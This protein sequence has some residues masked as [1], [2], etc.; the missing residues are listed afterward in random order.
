MSDAIDPIIEAAGL[1][2]GTVLLLDA[3]TL[4]YWSVG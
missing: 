2:S 3:R 4:K 1:R